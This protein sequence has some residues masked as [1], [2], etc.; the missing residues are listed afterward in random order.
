MIYAVQNSSYLMTGYQCILDP[1]ANELA[2]WESFKIT[3]DASS[4]I[5]TATHLRQNVTTWPIGQRKVTFDP[6]KVSRND[7]SADR[8]LDA[9]WLAL[10]CRDAQKISTLCSIPTERLR[11]CRE[12]ALG[13]YFFS[14]VD[15]MKSY[16]RR[17]E[18]FLRI[19]ATAMEATDPDLLID[20]ETAEHAL[21]IAYP[22]MNLLYQLATREVD[23]FNSAFLDAVKLHKSFWSADTELKTSPYGFT[24]RA[25]LAYASMAYDAGMGTTSI[26][27][28]VPERLVTG[29]WINAV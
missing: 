3:S 14:W 25:P 7:T 8:W 28:Y 20:T 1:S 29:H 6:R 15:A 9:L 12:T 16:L 27:T 4:A 5:F 22:N 13:E 26:P 11:E 23:T 17:D 21:K 19:L 10:T 18:D 2:S 24:A